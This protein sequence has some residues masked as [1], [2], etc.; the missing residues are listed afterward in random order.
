MEL[1]EKQNLISQEH[2]NI[3]K[4]AKLLAEF[5]QR[6][7]QTTDAIAGVISEQTGVMMARIL[8]ELMMAKRL[9]QRPN[10]AMFMVVGWDGLNDMMQTSIEQLKHE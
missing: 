3:R 6:G 4:F 8:V 5:S 10:P 9:M 1:A 7:F 2:A